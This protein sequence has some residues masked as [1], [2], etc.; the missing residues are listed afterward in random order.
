MGTVYVGE[1][2]HLQRQVAIKLPLKASQDHRLHARFLRE[3]R[4]VSQLNHPNIAAIYDYGETETG[5]PFIVMELLHGRTL[6][7]LIEGSEL[8]LQRAV[9]IVEDVAHALSEAHRHG[10]IHRDIKPSNIILDERN[11]TKVL[12]FGLAKD[13]NSQPIPVSDPE[14]RTVL[15]NTQSGTIV[16]TPLYLSPEQARCESVDARS[17][18][19]VLGVLLY[20]SI[21]GI[22]PFAGKGMLDIAAQIIHVSPK[23]PSTFNS[24]IPAELDRISMKA[25]AKRPEERY[26]SAD[27]FVADLQNVELPE[28][29]LNVDLVRTQRVGTASTAATMS[30]LSDIFVR[31]RF[32][33]GVVVLALVLFGVLIW[34]VTSLWK[35]RPHQ[36]S[37][38]AQRWYQLGTNAL[39]EGTYFKAS[40]ALQQATATD[41]DFALAHARL[42]EAWTE[43]DYSDRAKDETIRA[44]SLV[45]NRSSLQPIDALYLQAITDIISRN[46]QGAINQ[47]SEIVK[48]VPDSEKAY[49]YF[50]L[51]R[52]F[53]KNEDQ[54]NAISN[55]KKVIQLDSQFA[56]AFLRLGVLYGRRQDIAGAESAFQKAV[57]IYRA[58]SNFEGVAEALYQHGVLYDN[59]DKSSEAK[60]QFEE[61]LTIARATGNEYQEIRSKLQLSSVLRTAGDTAT[62]QQYAN[63]VL[64]LAQAK[65]LENLTTSGLIDLGNAYFSRSDF[66]NA[67]Q[68]FKQA[69]D[70][71]QRYKGRRNE[72]RALLSLG[73]LKMSQDNPDEAVT[74]VEKA[75]RF[76]QDGGYRQETSQALLL[77]GRANRAKG[78]YDAALKAFQQQLEIARVDGNVSRQA[79]AEE[80]LGTVLLRRELYPE[81]LNHF[82]N[83]YSLFSK[84]ENNLA[85]A[86][87][88]MN[89]ASVLLALGRD[90]DAGGILAEASEKAVKVGNKQLQVSI[91]LE[92]ARAAF[93]Q[94]N[95]V[96]AKAKSKKALDLAIASQ[97]RGNII[98]GKRLLGLASALSNQTREGIALCKEALEL[99]QQLKDPWVVSRTQLALAQA[100]MESGDAENALTNASAAEDNF[101]KTL[102]QDSEWQTLLVLAR[103]TQRQGDAVKARAYADRSSTSLA[104]LEQTWGKDFFSTYLARP[105]VG[106]GRQLLNQLLL[107]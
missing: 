18:L 105:D 6:S 69:L 61:S 44:T 5:Q 29:E 37:A 96:Q 20:E 46:F 83:S 75:L 89:R 25:L 71:A 12:D 14:A 10:I 62:A 54:E 104:K 50:D 17:D 98:E 81:A 49:A 59:Q 99:A 52:A 86:Y 91:E 63:E 36:P 68:Y 24:H 93:Q 101:T 23:A 77:F 48:H 92:L 51:G 57:Q 15:A 107:D 73:S 32:S 9:E 26:Q 7:S 72:A 84:S 106:Y 39:R 31:P 70:Y 64:Q 100:L 16:G 35:T 33:F 60:A 3:A 34:T 65:G 55:Y 94:R 66:E 13:L 2:L 19:F 79:F 11:V 56:P 47:Y 45:S 88:M 76:Y 53:E 21:A 1:D 30:R 103:A 43:L 41:N 22:H 85:I 87:N 67:Q 27:E 90:K 58:S 4:A 8:S 38:E 97:F 74:Y 95:F 78:D 102:Q 82:E 42:A 80:G 28:H 40:Q